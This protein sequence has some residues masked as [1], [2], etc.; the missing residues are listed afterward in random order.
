M[1]KRIYEAATLSVDPATNALRVCLISE[2]A[3]SS[4]D[5]PAAFFNEQNADRLAESLSFP[6]HPIDL[7]RPEHRDP[8]SAIG[9]IGSKVDIQVDADGNHSF[10]ADYVPAKSKPGVAEYLIE[11]GPRLGLS[12]YSESEG[13]E[14]SSTGKWVA[15]ALSP[16]DPYRSVD[17]VVAPGARG[18]FDVKV[19]EGLRRVIESSGGTVPP[20]SKEINMEIKDVEKVVAEQLTAALTPLTKIFEGL[21]ER[22]D[23][24]VVAE[25]QAEADEAAV[26]TAVEAAL[27]RAEKVNGLLAE[28]KLTKLAEDEVREFAKTVDVT[29]EAIEAKVASEKAKLS[30]A[31]QGLTEDH[32]ARILAEG[33]RGSG[34][35]FTG[36]G[37]VTGFSV[38]GFGEVR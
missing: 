2:G 34:I 17:V 28:A 7:E 26:K 25:A 16:N 3:G 5:Y 13:H 37:S 1:T 35:S 12:I 6:G 20:G 22:L 32:A 29:F 9:S 27:A 14:D 36:M 19:A 4:A 23:G 33:H 31:Q 18:K 8:M 38:P 10:W 21:V 11:Y 15:E 30:E 24:K